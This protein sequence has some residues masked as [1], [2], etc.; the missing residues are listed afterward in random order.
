MPAIDGTLTEWEGRPAL[1][2]ERTL[3]ASPARVW[4]AL[5]H[6]DEMDAWH[7]SP[8]EA[9]LRV[10]G[11]VRYLG[12]LDDGTVKAIEPIS[13]LTYTWGEDDLRWEL[14]EADGGGTVLTLTHAFDDRLKAA[15][16]GAGWHVCLGRLTEALDGAGRPED[17]G[18]AWSDFNPEYEQKFGIDPAEATPPPAEH[19][20]GKVG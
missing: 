18:K 19:V 5:T 16:D 14:E 3:K 15:R 7:P 20:V 8:F 4:R 12:K 17:E 11:A 1:R 13:L 2:F 6:A 10:G 9:D